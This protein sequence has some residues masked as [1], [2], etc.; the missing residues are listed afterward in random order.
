MKCSKYRRRVG[1]NYKQ[2][3][4]MKEASKDILSLWTGFIEKL[5]LKQALKIPFCAQAS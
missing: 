1:Y 3:T 5:S 4:Q 2:I